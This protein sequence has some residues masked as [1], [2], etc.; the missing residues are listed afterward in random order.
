MNFAI[1]N[2]ILKKLI[3][4]KKYYYIKNVLLR[5]FLIKNLK[6]FTKICYFRIL[7]NENCVL[8]FFLKIKIDFNKILILFKFFI[9]FNILKKKSHFYYNI[10]FDYLK[11]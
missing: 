2:I 10:E 8:I 5:I 6:K 1:D 3:K 9:K 11:I 7:I 4:S